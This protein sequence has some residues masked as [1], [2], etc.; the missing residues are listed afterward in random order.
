M[1]EER[2]PK[3]KS[4]VPPGVKPVI[5][6]AEAAAMDAARPAAL[7]SGRVLTPDRLAL[8]ASTPITSL[9]PGV[10][11]MRDTP[12]GETYRWSHGGATVLVKQEDVDYLLS[13]NHGGSRACCGGTGR[14]DYFQSAPGG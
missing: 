1:M 8:T 4:G 5:S 7:G 13:F 9:R 12:S 14:R 11:V 2:K 6:E 3:E 10:I